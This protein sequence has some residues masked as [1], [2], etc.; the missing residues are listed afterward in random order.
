MDATKSIKMNIFMNI[1]LTMSSFIFQFLS[2]PYVSRVLLPEGTGKISFATSLVSYFVLFSQL[3]IPTYGV[4]AC[5]KVR[6]NKIELSRTVHELLFLNCVITA[7]VYFIYLILVLSVPKLKADKILYFVSG[8]TIILNTLGIEWLYRA[9]EEY[10]YITVRSVIF[11][12]IAIILL[13][14]FINSPD[15]YI[16]YMAICVFAT[17]MSQVFNLFYTRKKIYISYLGQYNIKKHLKSVLIFFLM[18]CATTVY[19]HLDSVMLGFLKTDSIVGYYNAATKIKSF[20]VA[21]VTSLGTVL[22]P[23]ATHYIKSGKLTEFNKMSKGALTSVFVFG[24]TFT[25]FSII[26]SEHIILLLSGEQ[27]IPS[28]LPMKVIM[29]TVLFIGL[30]NILGIQM[31]VPLGR[32]KVVLKSEILGAIINVLVNSLLIPK[33]DAVG[34]AIGTLFAELAVLIVQMI[35]LRDQI[36]EVCRDFPVFKF[37]A[38]ILI[39]GKISSFIKVFDLKVIFTLLGGGIL[40]FGIIGS[41]VLCY[42]TREKRGKVET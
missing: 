32:E 21:I 5:A 8:L 27:Y 41:Y 36:L 20:L 1:L 39:G 38:I 7:I 3:G 15:D 29:P 31:L 22:L 16:G 30:T 11:K 19:T 40:Y 12:F 24:S 25:L 6:N 23:R 28:I 42:L 34:A 14:L 13:F 35:S 26:F 4:V 10:A 18:S 2:F 9:L 17:N 37:I 33:Y